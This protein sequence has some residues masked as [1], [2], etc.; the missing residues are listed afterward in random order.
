MSL[1]TTRRERELVRIQYK[2][3]DSGSM[4]ASHRN[5]CRYLSVK[6]PMRTITGRSEKSACLE[7]FPIHL[8]DC[9]SAQFS[10]KCFR[11]PLG[12]PPPRLKSLLLYDAIQ[13]KKKLS[14]CR[15][16]PSC[17]LHLDPATGSSDYDHD[18][19][20]KDHPGSEATRGLDR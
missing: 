4:Y 6:V 13:W 15:G 14:I 12:D 9:S 11:L 18:L 1:A 19:G 5:S 2:C 3:V 17:D 8:S 20:I 7:R 16:P 10:V